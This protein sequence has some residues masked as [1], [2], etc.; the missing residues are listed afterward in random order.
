MALAP[1]E[2][3]L[4]RKS[5]LGWLSTWSRRTSQCASGAPSIEQDLIAAAKA[6]LSAGLPGSTENT[7]DSAD[8]MPVS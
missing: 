8:W 3:Q 7:N 1:G 6:D 4:M 5:F 2:I